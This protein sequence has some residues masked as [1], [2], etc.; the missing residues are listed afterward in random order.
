MGYSLDCCHTRYGTPIANEP[1]TILIEPKGGE[2]ERLDLKI[3]QYIKENGFDFD[4][5]R[6]Y[7]YSIIPN[8]FECTFEKRC[9][10]PLNFMQV[11]G[12][13]SSFGI[14]VTMWGLSECIKTP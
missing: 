11:C 14:A 2:W 10:R 8:E 4:R 3:E 6:E 9:K 5:V 13:W 7:I 12:E 1:P